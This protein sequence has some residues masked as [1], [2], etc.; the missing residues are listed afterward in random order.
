VRSELTAPVE[1]SLLLEDIIPEHC[2]VSAKLEATGKDTPMVVVVPIV[3]EVMSTV[4]EQVT[5]LPTRMYCP[6]LVVLAVTLATVVRVGVQ[7]PPN[8]LGYPVQ[9]DRSPEDG[10]PRAPPLTTKAPA[11]P[12]LTPRAVTTPVP[13]V[14][15]EGATLAPPPCTSAPEA[16]T[17]DVAHVEELEKY[18]MP[19]LVPAT[20]NAGVLVAVATEINPPVKL[21]LVTVPAPAGVPQVP[22]PR[23]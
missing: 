8:T 15:V 21:T 9:L 14:I 10:V 19:P 2:K 11:V 18:G 12:V 17:A 5:I 20:V 4:P 16:R 6:S 1:P 7:V 23:Q 3:V 13:V 22:S